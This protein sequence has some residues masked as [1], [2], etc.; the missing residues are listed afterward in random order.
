MEKEDWKVGDRVQQESSDGSIKTGAVLSVKEDEREVYEYSY[1]FSSRSKPKKMEK[2][3]SK[4]TVKWD[5]GKEETDDSYRFYAEDSDFEREF[6]N[7]MPAAAERINE[8]LNLASKYLAEAV[9]ISEEA[10]VPFTSHISFLSQAYTPMS[11][12][13]KFPD[14]PPSFMK[15]IAGIYHEYKGW[16]H[17]QVC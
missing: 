15:E 11:F 2:F 13:E 10:G 14:V 9:Q 12:A 5:D 8:K 16:E 3:I 7:I 6:R 17:S 4:L 1:S